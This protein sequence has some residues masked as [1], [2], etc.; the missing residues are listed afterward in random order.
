M[1]G[2][3]LRDTF[4]AHHAIELEIPEPIDNCLFSQ[5]LA[6]PAT[7]GEAC[8][9]VHCSMVDRSIDRPPGHYIGPV[10]L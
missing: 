3:R 8:A 6:R 5:L 4:P 7:A 10:D 2:N 9:L 1:H